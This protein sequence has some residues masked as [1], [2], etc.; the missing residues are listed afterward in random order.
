M[1]KKKNKKQKAVYHII[2]GNSDFRPTK[3]HLEAVA[4]AFKAANPEAKFVA[5]DSS[6]SI[7]R[8]V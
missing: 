2:V 5:T 7:S 8:L 4:N 6:V 1:S 3:S